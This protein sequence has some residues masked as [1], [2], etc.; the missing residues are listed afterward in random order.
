EFAI[1][2]PG[3]HIGE[4]TILAEC[5][6]KAVQ[7][8]A[9]DLSQTPGAPATLPITISLGVACNDPAGGCTFVS[10][11]ALIEAADKALYAAKNS[12]RNRVCADQTPANLASSTPIAAAPVAPVPQAP[13]HASEPAPR[14]GPVVSQQPV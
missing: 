3:V 5:A 10:I 13:S 12:G 4:A 14:A 1:L 7:N 6:R 2:V 11:E 8:P 9:F